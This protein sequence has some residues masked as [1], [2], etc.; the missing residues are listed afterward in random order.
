MMQTKGSLFVRLPSGKKHLNAIFSASLLIVLILLVTRPAALPAWGFHSLDGR[1]NSAASLPTPTPNSQ[2]Y[3]LGQWGPLMSWPLVAVHMLMMHTG[4]VLVWDAWELNTT[5]S[6]RLWDPNTGTFTSVPDDYSAVFCAGQSQLADG[7]AI[8]VGGHNGAETGITRTVTFD[9]VS[10]LWAQQAN[11]NYARWYPSSITLSD[12]RVMALGGEITSGVDATIPEVYDPGANS[13]TLLPGANLDVG[14]DYPQSYLLPNGLLFMSTGPSDGISRTL[15][16][17][18]QSWSIVGPSPVPDGTTAMYLPGKIIAT[19]GGDPVRN[20]AAIIDLNEPSPTWQLTSPMAYPRTQHNLVLLP[21]GK[22]LAVGGT[23]Q[24]SLTTTTGYILQAEMWDPNSQAWSTMAAMTDPRMY[25]STAV[26]LPDGTVLS[27]GGGRVA[28]ANDYLS[29]QIY[30]PPYLFQGP[31]PTIT[32]APASTSYG[33]SMNIQTPDAA[34]IASVAFIRMGSVTHTFNTDQRY[35][36][37]SFTAGADSLTVQS[38]S[39][40][41]IAP[42]GYY[43]LFIVNSSGIPSVASIL[44]LGGPNPVPTATVPSTA[45]PFPSTTAT[46]TTGPSPVPSSTPTNT[47][48]SAPTSTPT[49]AP[50]STPTPAT[51]S[52]FPST[53]VLDNFNRANG[54][55]G[56]NW[57]G[58]SGGYN[59]TSNQLHVGTGGDI[60]WNPTIFGSNQE[61]YY[62]L[63]SI[64]PNG[65]EID[66]LLKAQNPNYIGNGVLEVSYDPHGHQ[67]S[68][69]TYTSTSGWVQQGATMPVTFNAGDQFGARAM[70]DGTVNVYRN[71]ALLGSAGV[72]SWPYYNAGGYI[73]LWTVNAAA[74]VVDDFGGGGVTSA[75]APT[76]TPTSTPTNTP[77]PTS[78][79][80]ATPLQPPTAT[81]TVGPS[82][83]PTRTPT[84]TPTSTRTPTTTITPTG[85]NTP[86]PTNTP[87]TPVLLMGVQTVGANQDNNPSGIAEAFVY[88]AVTSGT[89]NSLAVYLDSY[90][91]AT[92]VV[93]G[94][95]SNTT[96]NSPGGLLTTGTINNPVRGAWNSVSVPGV[97]LTAGTKYWIA[98]LGPSNMGIVQ[99]RDA[100]SGAASIVSAQ[101]NLTTLPAT[102]SSGTTY[103]NSPMSAYVL[104]K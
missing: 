13:W 7:R 85:T 67:V 101:N 52:A 47:P 93:L 55:I 26:L 37:L 68:V 80:T 41:N 9:P 51:S 8:V 48:V 44:Q 24:A 49:S 30:Y 15:N 6:A 100:T 70:V 27:A 72:T 20:T 104:Q 53:T 91:T 75:L 18:T 36:P 40:G 25:H 86:L 77:P 11:L 17:N 69:W 2:A 50:T 14:G 94:L 62:T 42:P 29:A 90:N 45:T 64:D 81:P 33:A 76:F 19:G 46:P 87:S 96:S 92:Q 103:V 10:E 79:P 74:T 71:G 54:A 102:W 22:V 5:P 97:N 78:T 39:N 16:L 58:V 89:A 65:S 98:V 21:T 59:I 95:Y 84:S 31:R 34:S 99:F 73:G 60:Y 61:A 28:P 82:S 38:P 56:G 1:I 3:T 23:N 63:A 32:S 57:S 43:M 35:I 4:Q 83:T 88:T 12:G 66:L